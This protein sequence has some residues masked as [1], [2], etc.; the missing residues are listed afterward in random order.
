[1]FR[2]AV[3]KAPRST[4]SFGEKHKTNW[5]VTVVFLSSERLLSALQACWLSVSAPGEAVYVGALTKTMSNCFDNQSGV[6][7][8]FQ[9]KAIKTCKDN[10]QTRENTRMY[11]PQSFFTSDEKR[12]KVLVRGQ[13][14]RCQGLLILYCE[15]H[16]FSS[17]FCWTLVDSSFTEWLTSSLIEQHGSALKG[18]HLLIVEKRSR[19]YGIG[20]S[21]DVLFC[22]F[23]HQ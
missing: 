6:W 20:Q 17:F 19:S 22:L 13:Q 21:A 9:T 7:V 1:M 23:V 11:S 16:H 18:D 14:P 8:I 3:D 4:T 12:E 10:L 2:Q 15:Y 5:N